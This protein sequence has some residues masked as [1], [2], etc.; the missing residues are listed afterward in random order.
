MC[1]EEVLLCV[2]FPFFFFFFLSFVMNGGDEFS[3]IL[4][5][6]MKLMMGRDES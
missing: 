2:F 1:Y 4:G 6:M 3:E 5:W